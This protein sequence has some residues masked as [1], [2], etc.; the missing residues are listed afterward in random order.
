MTRDHKSGRLRSLR[1]SVPAPRA[2]REEEAS[3]LRQLRG[4]TDIQEA[5]RTFSAALRGRVARDALRRMK[6][7][8]SVDRTKLTKEQFEVLG[9]KGPDGAMFLNQVA[10]N[11]PDQD[12]A[13]QVMRAALKIPN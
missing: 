9:L 6:K 2:P 7:R 3:H 12:A 4:G 13:E 10:K 11:V 5:L 8:K 1:P